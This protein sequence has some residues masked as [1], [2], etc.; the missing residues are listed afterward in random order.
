M[1]FFGSDLLKEFSS[2][3]LPWRNF[4]SYGGIAALIVVLFTLR[5]YGGNPHM[6]DSM[7]LLALG[8]TFTTGSFELF[9]EDDYGRVL[10]PVFLVF[11]TTFWFIYFGLLIK[12][13]E[14]PNY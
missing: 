11:V 10:K 13:K 7:S 6:V 4:I 2:L 1:A 12:G 14:Y 9:P 8:I 5:H 3:D